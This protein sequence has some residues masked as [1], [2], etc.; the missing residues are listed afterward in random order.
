MNVAP[1]GEE[2]MGFQRAPPSLLMGAEARDEIIDGARSLVRL[3]R[4]R[5]NGRSLSHRTSVL[6][7]PN[8]MNAS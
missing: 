3:A 7:S 1:D 4:D 8:K 5:G 6:N 2:D